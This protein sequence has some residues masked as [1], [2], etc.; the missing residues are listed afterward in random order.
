MITTVCIA[1]GSPF[2][3]GVHFGS[4]NGSSPCKT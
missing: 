1:G 2:D 4:D 3:S